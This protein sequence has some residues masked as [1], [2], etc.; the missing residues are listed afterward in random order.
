LIESSSRS[1]S[2]RMKDTVVLLGRTLTRKVKN[3][4]R[5]RE[6]RI[7]ISK[8]IVKITT[9]TANCCIRF[10]FHE[11]EKRESGIVKITMEKITSI[12]N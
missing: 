1:G 4:D 2:R 12:E 5:P 3:T 6:K 8:K 9:N 10:R 11:E 7:W